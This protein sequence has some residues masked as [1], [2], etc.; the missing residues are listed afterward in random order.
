MK[1][2]QKLNSHIQEMQWNVD[3][4][5]NL[6]SGH[7]PVNQQE[8]MRYVKENK[9]HASKVPVETVSKITALTEYYDQFFNPKKRI[10]F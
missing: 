10:R 5:I 4:Y 8:C 1:E 7:R 6:V 9:Y 2:H 3:T